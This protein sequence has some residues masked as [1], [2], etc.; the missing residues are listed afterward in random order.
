VREGL[1]AGTILAR[2]GLKRL[3]L[4][5]TLAKDTSLAVQ[6][7]ALSTM[8]PAPGQGALAI[9]CR[10]N[11]ARVRKFLKAL[12][13]P[14]VAACITAERAALE[15]LGGGCHLPLGA[16]GTIEQKSL[17]LNAVLVLPD[18]SVAVRAAGTASVSQARRLGRTVARQILAKG[19]KAILAQLEP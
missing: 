11:D 6:A 2:A 13:N 19:G 8:L 16:L 5:A 4:L 12:H 14:E 1:Y 9:E 7:L 18:G 10:A 3:G 15:A 17:H